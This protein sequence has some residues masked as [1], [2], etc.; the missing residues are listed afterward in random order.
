MKIPHTIRLLLGLS[1]GVF[2]SGQ[3]ANLPISALTAEV[4]SDQSAIYYG[5]TP[6]ESLLIGNDGSA[7]TGGLRSF[8]LLDRNLDET[9]QVTVG[10]TKVAGVLYD[11]GERGRDLVVS[12]AA[13]DSIIRVFKLDGLTQVSGVEKKALGDWSSLCT[14]RSQ[15]GAQYFY[16]FGKKQAMQFLVRPQESELEILEIQTFPVPVEASSCA[17][18]PEDGVVYIAAEDKTIYSF[19]AEESTAA[20]EIQTVGEATDDISGLAV[21]VTRKSHYLFVAQTDVIEVYTS[22]FQLKGSLSLIGAEDIEIEATVIYQTNSTQYPYGV[23]GYAVETAESKGFGVSSLGPAFTKLLLDPNTSYTPRSSCPPAQEQPLNGFKNPDGTLSCFAGF[24]GPKCEEIICP[25]ACSNQGTCVGPNECECRSPH[26]GPDCSWIGVAAKYE[27]DA[28]GG[29]GDDPAIWI[30]SRGANESTIITTTKSELGAGLAVFDLAGNLLQTITAG[31]PNNVDVIYGFR[32]GNRTV[33][34]A[35]AACR[36]DD[37][38][39]LFEI[40]PDGLLAPIPGGSQPTPPDYTVYGSCVYRSSKTGKQYLFVNEKSGQYLQ[41][42][43]TASSNGTLSTTLVRQFQA[44]TGGQ[45]EGCVADEENA[46][47]FIGEEPYGLWR[48]DA[49]PDASD[50][51]GVLIARTGDGTLYADVEGVALVVGPTPDKGLVIVSAQGVSAYSVYRRAE[52]N[53]HVL[54]FTIQPSED[55]DIDGVTNTDGVTAVGTALNADFPRGLVVV[56][57]DANQL[58]GGGTAELASFKLVSLEDVLG[59]D[60]GDLL[61]EVDEEWDPRAH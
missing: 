46:V 39:C 12:I 9:A 3:A 4:E 40:T 45:V 37:T 2:A 11:V 25:N 52:P 24:T 61:D 15:R 1:L 21:Y 59:V 14:W 26:A 51:S 35:Y 31:E 36:E 53:E 34:L 29:D 20:P 54:T 32:A 6:G 23:I 44:G 8:D 27:T 19:T 60:G 58:A 13:P 50:D 49:E 10:R 17:V 56:H 22:D 57:D 48:Y 5:T 55:G 33:D 47:V 7:A 28:N 41:Y 30:S 38:L 18:S 16:L 43:L 42:E